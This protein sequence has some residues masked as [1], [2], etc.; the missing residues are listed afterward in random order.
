MRAYRKRTWAAMAVNMTP[1]IDVVFLIIIFFIIMI[2]F[3]EMHIRKIN[4]PKADEARESLVDKNFILPLIIKS[5]KEI[6]LDRTLV[7]FETLIP[8]LEN[9]QVGIRAMQ[10]QILADESVPYEVVKTA[11]HKL[12]AAGIGKIEFSTIK[13]SPDPLQ[14]GPKDE[15]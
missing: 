7:S 5:P 12:S 6:Y 15:S 8:A 10:I 1:L 3:S 11:L 14:E 2:N 9:E 13:E 4:L